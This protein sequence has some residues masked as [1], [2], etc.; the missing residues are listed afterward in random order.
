MK[1]H[2][3]LMMLLA[4]AGSAS[5]ELVLKT[6][7]KIRICPNVLTTSGKSIVYTEDNGVVTV[8]TPDFLV[9]KTFKIPGSTGFSVS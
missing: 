4:I 8:Y 9:D 2:F 7:S 1:K 6:T 3:T 5:A